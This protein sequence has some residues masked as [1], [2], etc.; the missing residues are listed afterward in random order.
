M[1]FPGL[2]T[3]VSPFSTAPLYYPLPFLQGVSNIMDLFDQVPL[4]QVP[5]R[6]T[7]Y[8]IFPC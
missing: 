5:Q 3:T 1:V 8:M 6:I 2:S 4:V 7:W